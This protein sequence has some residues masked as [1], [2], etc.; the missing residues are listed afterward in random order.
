MKYQHSLIIGGTGMLAEATLEICKQSKH[1]TLV[2][3]NALD[4][5]KD[6][7]LTEISQGVLDTLLSEKDIVVGKIQNIANSQDSKRKPK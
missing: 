2:S 3:R 5:V 7:A 6:N 4:F 1:A